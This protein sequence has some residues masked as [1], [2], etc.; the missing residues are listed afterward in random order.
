VSNQEKNDYVVKALAE[1][2]FCIEAETPEKALDLF[3]RE[4]CPGGEMATL[5]TKSTQW[6]VNTA[7]PG[8]YVSTPETVTV[9]DLEEQVLL[10]VENTKG[11]DDPLG[12]AGDGPENDRD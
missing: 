5:E 2:H 10:R 6:F 11:W 4:F 3:W 12:L 1:V 9:E 7:W 8:H